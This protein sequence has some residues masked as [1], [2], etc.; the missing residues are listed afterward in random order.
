MP[1][2]TNK[3]IYSAPV[4]FLGHVTRLVIRSFYCHPDHGSPYSPAGDSIRVHRHLMCWNRPI[5]QTTTTHDPLLYISNK[6]FNVVVLVCGFAHRGRRSGIRAAPQ[7]RTQKRTGRRTSL[8]PGPELA[9]VRNV[10]T[11]M[12]K[13]AK[14]IKRF[15]VYI[16]ARTATIL[17]GPCLKLRQNKTGPHPRWR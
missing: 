8:T 4:L 9:R 10:H 11:G 14:R 7:T 12:I 2:R 13:S 6:Q 3:F 17:A 16:Q 15:L 5:H 1:A